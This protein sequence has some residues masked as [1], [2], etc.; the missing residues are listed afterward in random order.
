MS[1]VTAFETFEL[2]GCAIALRRYAGPLARELY[3]SCQPLDLAADAGGQAEAAY[4]AILE[5][6]EREGADADTVVSETVL[7]RN[8][9]TDGQAVRAARV[10]VFGSRQGAETLAI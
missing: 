5:V 2:N 6:L 4:G 9:A 1:P 3:F 8:A 10:A 7:L